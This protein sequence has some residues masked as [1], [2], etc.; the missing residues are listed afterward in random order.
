MLVCF[1][2]GIDLKKYGQTENG[3]QNVVNFVN[4]LIE[5]LS[6]PLTS[7]VLFHNYVIFIL[8]FP[9]CLPFCCTLIG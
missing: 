6:V 5:F 4:V 2:K 8:V 9:G 3:S 7:M 1:R